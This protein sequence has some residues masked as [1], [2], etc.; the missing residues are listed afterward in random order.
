MVARA[1]RRLLPPPLPPLP[2]PPVIA[3]RRILPLCLA[4]LV[5]CA[6]PSSELKRMVRNSSRDLE[7]EGLLA[8]IREANVARQQRRIEKVRAFVEAGEVESAADHFYAGLILA[9][10]SNPGDLQVAAAMGLKAAELGE[11]RGFRVAAEAIDRT[12]RIRG[13]PQRYGTQF[14]YLEVI[15]EWRLDPLDPRTS[16]EERAAMGVAP[17]AELEAF[18][19][20]LNAGRAAD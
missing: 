15:D 2:P 17:L 16:D 4:L 3:V 1:L 9:T 8:G 19:R 11:E 14:S 20:D 6:S 5:A 12:L 13:E 10:S 18:V 7:G